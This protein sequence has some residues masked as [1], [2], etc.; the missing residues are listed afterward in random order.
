MN[1]PITEL[2]N[3]PLDYFLFAPILICIMFTIGAVITIIGVCL[4]E[5]I[6]NRDKEAI[7]L[8]LAILFVIWVIVG[9]VYFKEKE[10][11]TVRKS[12]IEISSE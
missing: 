3:T 7:E 11:V 12:Y 2:F 6:F 5:A 4:H 1:E 9:I 8:L 10:E